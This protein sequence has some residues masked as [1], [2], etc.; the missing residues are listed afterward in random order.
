VGE[1][2]RVVHHEAVHSGHSYSFKGSFAAWPVQ[3][4][5]STSRA[6]QVRLAFHTAFG[7]PE[8]LL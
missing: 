8:G 3:T 5:I 7:P 2:Q 6:R 4:A 1:R